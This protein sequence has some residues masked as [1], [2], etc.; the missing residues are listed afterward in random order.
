[1]EPDICTK[2]DKKLSEKLRAKFPATTHGYSLAK[3]TCLD[4]AFSE[5]FKLEVS[6]VEGQSL[7]Q[8]EKIRRKR[9]DE[10]KIEK[11]K[12]VGHFLV[13]RLS[14]N[15][16]FCACPSKNVIKRDASGNKGCCYVANAFLSRLELIWP[17]SSLKIS[18][19]SKNICFWQKAP[20]V[21]GLIKAHLK[22]GTYLKE[23]TYWKEGA[24]SS[25]YSIY[26]F[27]PQKFQFHQDR[28][29]A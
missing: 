6:P 23:G 17:I 29:S 25:H 7:Q 4:D 12:D 19:M 8:K 26:F 27:F 2:I 22:G 28:G 16:D 3:I 24:K 14:Q 13:Q 15:F 11:P 18:K 5:C 1:M 21:N 10:K 9:K 20:G